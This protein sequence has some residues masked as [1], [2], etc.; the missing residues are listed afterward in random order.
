MSGVT[1]DED[2]KNP[3]IYKYILIKTKKN[4]EMG[5]NLQV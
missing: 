3:E 5:K 4:E 1:S 2:F